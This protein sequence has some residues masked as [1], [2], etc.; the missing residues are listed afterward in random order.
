MAAGIEQ[1]LKSKHMSYAGGLEDSYID[2][3]AIDF[4]QKDKLRYNA[5]TGE[6]QDMIGI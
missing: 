1:A 5:R 3:L 4:I 2:R 6:L